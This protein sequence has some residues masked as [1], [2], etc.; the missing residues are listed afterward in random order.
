MHWVLNLMSLHR[1]NGGDIKRFFVEHPWWY[2]SKIHDHLLCSFRNGRESV[3]VRKGTVNM[4]V[5]CVEQCVR[6]MV[7][8]IINHN[9]K[10]ANTSLWRHKKLLERVWWFLMDRKRQLWS[11]IVLLWTPMWLHVTPHGLR[12]FIS[13]TEQICKH[14]NSFWV[15][16]RCVQYSSFV[17]KQIKFC[18]CLSS[19]AGRLLLG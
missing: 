2:Y 8:V 19:Y 9:L 13:T 17:K 16:L 6:S 15:D 18:S 7:K 10:G 4:Q 14:W 11:R 3:E 1:W 5:A 12:S